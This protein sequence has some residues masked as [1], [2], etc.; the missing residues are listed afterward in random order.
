M[1]GI[2]WRSDNECC[3]IQYF[4]DGEILISDLQMKCKL[5]KIYDHGGRRGPISVLES[6]QFDFK[7]PGQIGVAKIGFY[8][9][10]EDSLSKEKIVPVYCLDISLL[11]KK[12]GLYGQDSPRSGMDWSSCLK[13]VSCHI[14]GKINLMKSMGLEIF[15]DDFSA[16]DHIKKIIADSGGLKILTPEDIDKLKQEKPYNLEGFNEWGIMGVRSPLE[17]KIIQEIILNKNFR[18]E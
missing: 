15:S 3:F 1:A 9:G 13:D 7:Y 2:N 17:E 11:Y 8:L 10:E 12:Y 5:E 6:S 16:E 4:K 14:L 18:T